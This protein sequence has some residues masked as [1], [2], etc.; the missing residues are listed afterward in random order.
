MARKPKLKLEIT[1]VKLEPEQAVLTCQCYNGTV[2]DLT[3]TSGN[4]TPFYCDQ[5]GGKDTWSYVRR[6]GGCGVIS[7][8]GT[9]G[10]VAAS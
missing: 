2:T 1:R 4:M 9:R 7:L 5:V 3:S 6:G 10:A 8:G